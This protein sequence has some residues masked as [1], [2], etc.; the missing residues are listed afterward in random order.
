MGFK[1]LDFKQFSQKEMIQRSKSFLSEI[2]TRRTVREFSSKPVPLEVVENCIK[3][4]GTAPSGAN[5]QPWTFAIVQDKKVKAK[6]RIAAEKEENEFYSHRATKEWLED[7]NQFGTNWKKPFL[8]EAPYLIIVFRKIY[9]LD[10]KGSQ[11]K[12]YYV[13]ESVGIAS[14]FLLAALHNAGLAT[15]THTPSPMNFLGKILDRPDNEKAY[16]LIP[17]GYPSDNAEV[18]NIKKKPFSEISKNI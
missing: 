16:L 5:K 9:D 13:N 1:K 11:R 6:I 15:L 18:P 14:G 10:D 4:A 7:L 3:S 8:E 12:N 2:S 17:V